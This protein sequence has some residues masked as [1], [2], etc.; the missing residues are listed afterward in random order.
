MISKGM[1]CAFLFGL[2]WTFVKT[3]NMY[4]KQADWKWTEQGD[5]ARGKKDSSSRRSEGVKGSKQMWSWR[6]VPDSN[7]IELKESPRNKVKESN[8][9]MVGKT[10]T[11]TAPFHI[12]NVRSRTTKPQLKRKLPRKQYVPFN[13]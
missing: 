13:R 10:Y 4:F 11:H 3:R 6:D 9:D 12:L 2:H 1:K 7:I 5:S 8:D